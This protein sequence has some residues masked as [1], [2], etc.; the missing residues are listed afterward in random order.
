MTKLIP[1]VSLEPLSESEFDAWVEPI[2]S[3]YA[4]SNLRAGNWSPE[5]ALAKAREATTSL[6]PAGVATPGHHLWVARDGETGE[7]VGKLW[8]AVRTCATGLEAYVYFVGVGEPHQGKG[9][10]RAVMN[11]GAEAARQLGAVSMALN[12][13][14][15]NTAATHLYD[16]L[17]YRTTHQTMRLEL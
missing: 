17:G 12:V 6:L 9:Y 10:G 2:N 11:A 14:S 4:Q 16:T 1:T 3:G 5:E 15:A 13:F 7:P 8:L